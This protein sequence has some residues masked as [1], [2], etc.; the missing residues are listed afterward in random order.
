MGYQIDASIENGKPS[1]KI[2]DISDR[3]LCLSWTYQNSGEG[4]KDIS[5]K[6]IKRLFQKLLLLTLRDDLNNVR[7]FKAS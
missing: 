1:L 5:Q 2:W 7:V 4:N 3:S 6:E